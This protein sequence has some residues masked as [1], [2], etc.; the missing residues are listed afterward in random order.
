[1]TGNEIVEMAATAMS[2]SAA[3]AGVRVGAS[4]RCRS[5]TS[6][7]LA[8]VKPRKVAA[9]AT[10]ATGA[11]RRKGSMVTGDLHMGGVAKTKR[12]QRGKVRHSA[13]LSGKTPMRDVVPPKKKQ[14]REG[15]GLGFKC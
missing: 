5:A 2:F 4:G 10:S 3:V 13:H 12:A 1:M 14:I 9:M 11:S 8:T 15:S 6:A 7:K